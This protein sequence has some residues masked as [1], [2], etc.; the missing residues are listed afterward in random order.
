MGVRLACM[1]AVLGVSLSVRAETDPCNEFRAYLNAG[2]Q[3]GVRGTNW[4]QALR[5]FE[6]A[7]SFTCSTEDDVTLHLYRGIVL[8][9]MR[10]TDPAREAF[11]QA[12]LLKPRAQLP[13]TFGRKV[14]GFLEEVR[15]DLPP[16]PEPPTA[17]AVMAAAAKSPEPAPAATTPVEQ[18]ALAVSGPTPPPEARPA[19]SPVAAALAPRE[20]PPSLALQPAPRSEAPA[21][22]PAYALGAASVVLAGA[23]TYFGLQAR[24]QTDLARQAVYMDETR[25]HL[26]QAATG[27]LVANVLFCVAGSVAAG[28]VVAFLW[29]AQEARP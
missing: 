3:L 22:R 26:D 24:G 28:A 4:E 18:V 6:R 9:N 10:R 23:A 20:A 13:G 14:R 29:P 17:P 16:E 8:F 2:V 15:A 7:L 21:F 12:L 5:Q 27:A 1:V 19:D 11:R 25:R